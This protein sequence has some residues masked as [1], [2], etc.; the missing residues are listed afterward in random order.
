MTGP[1]GTYAHLTKEVQR[2][3]AEADGNDRDRAAYMVARA[4]LLI[5]PPAR[6]ADMARKLARELTGQ[7]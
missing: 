7:A 4:A 5:V 1:A 6:A 3:V 2:L